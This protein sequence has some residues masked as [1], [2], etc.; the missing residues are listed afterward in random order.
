[1]KNIHKIIIPKEEPKKCEHDIIMKYGVV[2]CQNCGM[3]HNEILAENLN[4]KPPLHRLLRQF[5]SRI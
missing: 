4:K 5:W 2:Q 1:M 3:E